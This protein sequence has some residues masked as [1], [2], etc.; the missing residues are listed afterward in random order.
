MSV[1]V[2]PPSFCQPIGN[3]SGGRNAA[4][5]TSASAPFCQLLPW[6]IES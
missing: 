4:A 3:G 1:D 5:A 2:L 6:Q